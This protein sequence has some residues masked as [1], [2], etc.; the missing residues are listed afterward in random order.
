MN[1]DINNNNILSLLDKTPTSI[2]A[3]IH[4]T[5]YRYVPLDG[6]QCRNIQS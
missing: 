5:S 1:D 3:A 2:L 4:G 6:I